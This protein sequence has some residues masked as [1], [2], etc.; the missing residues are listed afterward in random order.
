VPIFSANS[1]KKALVNAFL[2]LSS[3][4]PYRLTETTRGAST[5]DR[6]TDYASADQVHSSWVLAPNPDQREIITIGG[7][8]WWKL[9]SK[10]ESD[11]SVND[12]PINLYSLLAPNTH[13]VQYDGQDS[14]MGIPCFVFNYA[15]TINSAGVSLDG[16]G[17]AW[18]GISDG[19]PHQLDLN[20]TVNSAPMTTHLVYSYGVKFDIQP[21]V[22]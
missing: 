19:L 7:Q 22:H 18:V 15:L 8:T 17:K 4:Y 1:A 5:L 9:N 14:V 13:D 3:A 11:P 12:A 10:W 20:A 2:K 16:S 6:T 21:P